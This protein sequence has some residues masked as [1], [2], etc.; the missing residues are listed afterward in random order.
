MSGR[1]RMPSE[2]GHT[3][4]AV[5]LGSVMAGLALTAAQV[6]TARAGVPATVQ[7][8][9]P[10]ADALPDRSAPHTDRTGER[11]RLP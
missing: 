1:H 11:P 10:S 7:P 4:G 9:R 5:L 2:D 6:Q 8:D 3:A